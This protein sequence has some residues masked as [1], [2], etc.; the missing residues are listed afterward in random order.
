MRIQRLDE[1]TI[2]QI[3]AGEVVENSA[4]VVKELV[5]NSLDAG[6]TH[7][8][9][10]L[11]AGGRQLL[12]VSDNGCG[13]TPDEVLAALER[14]ATSK[15]RAV[16]DLNELLSFGFR[17]EAIPSI[18]SISR[19]RLLSA[20]EGEDGFFVKVE[21]GQILDAGAV[22]RERGTT[23]EV[24]DLFFNVPARL[25]FQKSPSAD[26]AACTRTLKQLAIAHP[27]VWFELRVGNEVVFETLPADETIAGLQQR[28]QGIF[29]ADWKHAR[30]MTLEEGQLRLKIL[31]QPPQA[32]RPNRNDQFV[33]LNR[34]VV[35]CPAIGIAIREAMAH[36]LDTGRYPAFL[37]AV[38][39]PPSWV[40]VNVHPQKR[41]VRLRQEPMLR[42]TIARATH[43]LLA[44]W[45]LEP[46][47][48]V[49]E[50]SSPSD[51]SGM[52][53]GASGPSVSTSGPSGEAIWTAWNAR[54][55]ERLCE[56]WRP[57]QRHPEGLGVFG[58]SADHHL[59]EGR[60]ESPVEWTGAQE[61]GQNDSSSL[62][63]DLLEKTADTPSTDCPTRV[64]GLFH[65]PTE[66]I[67]IGN[68]RLLMGS[69]DGFWAAQ[70]PGMWLVD[71][72]AL[73]RAYLQECLSAQFE[74]QSQPLLLPER[75]LISWEECERLGCRAAGFDWRQ[76]GEDLVLT[77]IPSCLEPVEAADLLLEW[78][79]CGGLGSAFWKRCARKTLRAISLHKLLTFQA[80]L[81]REQG[82]LGE[83]L[84]V[85]VS[86]MGLATY[87]SG[88]GS[89]DTPCTPSVSAHQS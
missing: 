87:L 4:S 29:G 49:S 64:T 72:G 16:D 48:F 38:D 17:G 54:T 23:V 65:L 79:K 19:F 21:A 31:L 51:S 45:T 66:L 63:K 13:M 20:Q 1:I 83:P 88:H 53:L 55:E 32:H 68:Y 3:A 2:N 46:E 82:P 41:E 59:S 37:A 56:E 26:L 39:L 9:V 18:A 12:R 36:R 50:H 58:S 81:G 89:H 80:E 40:D 62:E 73:R 10:E 42:G 85:W 77:A 47:S 25:K 71:E 70:G 76:E 8:Q 15:L 84:R 24:R 11:T 14:H 43:C 60:R 30:G 86:E 52:S 69:E 5:E 44:Q 27:R 67:R 75:V 22:A 57:N 7:V 28:C 34:R 33:M 61:V 74:V 78:V 35:Q 6:A